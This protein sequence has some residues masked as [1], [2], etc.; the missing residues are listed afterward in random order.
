MFVAN[1][2]LSVGRQKRGGNYK[3]IYCGYFKELSQFLFVLVYAL[4]PNHQFLSND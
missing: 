2:C 1:E 4:Q 3:F